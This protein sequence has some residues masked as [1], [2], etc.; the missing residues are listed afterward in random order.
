MRSSFLLTF[1]IL[2]LK[3]KINNWIWNLV[4]LFRKKYLIGSE[5]VVKLYAVIVIV[6]C[7]KY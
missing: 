2:P 3:L 4:I 5:Q 1:H 7:G 6:G